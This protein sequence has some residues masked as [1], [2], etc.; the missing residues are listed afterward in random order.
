MYMRNNKN[1]IQMMRGKIA[2]FDQYEVWSILL[3]QHELGINTLKIQKT[4]EGKFICCVDDLSSETYKK[5][6]RSQI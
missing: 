4:I 6:E 3:H 5:H 1:Y 2:E